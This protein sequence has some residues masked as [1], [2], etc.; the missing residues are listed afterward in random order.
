MT[1]GLRSCFVDFLASVT[2]IL[3]SLAALEKPGR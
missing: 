2:G 3:G 1:T